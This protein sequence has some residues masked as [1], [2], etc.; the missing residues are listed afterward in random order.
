MDRALE[1][2]RQTSEHPDVGRIMR[3]H[4]AH[5]GHTHN[6]GTAA[7][8]RLRL[9]STIVMATNAQLLRFYRTQAAPASIPAQQTDSIA[10]R[11]VSIIAITMSVVLVVA[12]A[13]ADPYPWCAVSGSSGSTNCSF[14]TLGQCQATISGIGGFCEPNPSFTGPPAPVGHRQPMAKDL[15]AEILWD[16]Q[17]TIPSQKNPNICKGC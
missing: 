14:V 15:P 11:L 6:A 3:N 17:K 1:H 9:L 7:D 12:K 16:E 5:A 13:S 8:F 2:F 4:N 10:A